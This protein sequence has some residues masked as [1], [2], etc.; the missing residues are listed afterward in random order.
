[1]HDKP[2]A[3]PLGEDGKHKKYPWSKG[4]QI[5]YNENVQR[6]IE[7]IFPLYIQAIKEEEDR[8]AL[9]VVIDYFVEELKVLGP[10]S[11]HSS[12]EDVIGAINQYLKEETACQQDSEPRAADT[13]DIGTKHRWISDTVADLIATLAQ[14]FGEQFG[15]LFG[16]IFQNLLFFGREIRHAQDQAMVV[17]C[18]ADCCSRLTEDKKKMTIMSPFS[19]DIYK[20]SLR[21]AG[22]EDVNMRQNALY[23]MGAVSAC[24]DT[25]SNMAHSQAVL[26]CIKKYIEL[27]KNGTRAHKLVRDNA[28]SALGKMLISEP[29]SLPTKELLPVF[30]NALPLTGDFSENKYVYQVVIRF[31]LEQQSYIQSHIEQALTALGMALGDKEVEEDTK[32]HIAGCLKKICSDSSIQQIVQSKVS[33]TAKENIMKAVNQ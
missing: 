22:S 29:T 30:L 7:T 21:V 18:I 1:L 4:V 3:L 26:Q 27:P 14:L 13:Q 5:A 17:G 20:L 11:I 23:C 25:N 31:I 12:M 9:N 33:Q 2:A 24:C 6:L 32:K 28:V 10:Q 16:Q 15:Q 19:N 8:D